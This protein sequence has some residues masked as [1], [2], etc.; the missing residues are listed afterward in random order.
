[1][2]SRSSGVNFTKNYMLLYLYL[3]TCN[4]YCLWYGRWVNFVWPLVFGWP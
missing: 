2:A 1:V 4:L 3:F